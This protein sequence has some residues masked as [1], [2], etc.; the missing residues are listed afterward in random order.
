[1]TLSDVITVCADMRPEDRACVRAMCGTEPGDW[2]A[3]ERWKTDGPAWTLDQDGQPWVVGGMS[4]GNAWTGTMWMVARPGV[5]GETWRKVLRIA[6]MMLT[7]LRPEHP[8]HRHR[9]EALVL[10]GWTGAERLADRLGLVLEGTHRAMGS[11]MES[12]QRR[13]AVRA[14]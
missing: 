14:S 7:V 3:V 13:A 5:R 9:V 6:R 8:M 1:M 10:E 4:F 2:F 11:N 12:V